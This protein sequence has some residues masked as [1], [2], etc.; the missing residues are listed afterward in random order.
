VIP[1]VTPDEMAAIDQEAPEP[2]EVLIERAGAATAWAARRLL[3]GTYG[4]RVVVIAGKGNNGNDGRSAARR[5]ARWGSRVEVVDAASAPRALPRCDLVVDAAYGTGFR[6]TWSAPEPGTARV[7][8][9]DIPSGVDG[10][11]GAAV[12]TPLAADATV[13]FAAL[14]PGLVLEPGASLA[15]DVH[16][17]DI[18]LDVSRAR[19]HLVEVDDLRGWLPART[20]TTHKWKSA[21]WVVGGSP[22]LEGAAALTA[23]AAMRAGAGYVRWSS[24]G[25]GPGAAKPVEVVGTALPATG[26]GADVLADAER[27][28]AFVIGNGLG[29][30]R[31][32]A[33]A[34]RDVVAGSPRP[35]VVDADALTL[36]GPTVIECARATTVLTPHDG[37]LERITGAPPG[38]DR[39]GAARDLAARAGCVVLLKGRATVVADPTGA[40]LVSRF[41][42]ERLATLGSGDVLAGTIAA[43]AAQGLDPFLAAA[44]GAALHGRAGRVGWRRGLTAGDL[45]AQLPRA[46]DDLQPVPERSERAPRRSGP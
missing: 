41:G 1:I 17:A 21:V 43:L 27:F 45:V 42:D 5:L 11:S 44:A 4:R 15:G 30:D 39:I 9:V 19:A 2:V 6:G 35:V 23:S 10:T 40:V 31:A 16:V 12:G 33:P 22:G 8:A 29:L 36:L 14:K 24:P 46:L 25:T 18:G 3:G 13:T 38:A 7:L 32:H 28:G 26:W 20:A 37:E 34:V